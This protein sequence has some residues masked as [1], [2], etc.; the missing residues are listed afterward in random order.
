[1]AA[2][3]INPDN[4]ITL[5]FPLLAIL[6]TLC[7]AVAGWGASIRSDVAAAK[8]EVSKLQD[9]KADH[10]RDGDKKLAD[11]QAAIAENKNLT[12]STAAASTKQN[13]ELQETLTTVRIQLAARH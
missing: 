10:I 8:Q 7:L 2:L 12:V 1:M 4:S 6:I 13:A 11:L 9:W 3:K 5:P